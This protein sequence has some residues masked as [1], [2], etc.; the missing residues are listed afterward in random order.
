[1]IGQYYETVRPMYQKFLD[2]QRQY[3][4]FIIGEETD[5]AA[6]ILSSHINELLRFGQIP[7]FKIDSADI[8]QT[9]IN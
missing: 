7:N 9:S 8:E 6:Q 1:M 4:D 5:N 3:A 2:P